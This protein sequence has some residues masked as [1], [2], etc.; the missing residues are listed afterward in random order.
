[1]HL[2]VVHV[3]PRHMPLKTNNATKYAQNL[4]EQSS[5][6]AHRD[7]HEPRSKCTQLRAEHHKKRSS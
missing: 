4:H 5:A 3:D 2:N 1:M 7:G 6:W